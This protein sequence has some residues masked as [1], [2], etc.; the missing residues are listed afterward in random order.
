MILADGADEAEERAED[1]GKSAE[2]EYVNELGQ[3]VRRVFVSVLEVQDL[4]EQELEDGVE[5]FSRHFR[6]T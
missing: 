2:H 1:V 4:G 6:A 5:V 3:T